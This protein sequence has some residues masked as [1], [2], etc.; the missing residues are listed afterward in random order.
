MVC[1]QCHTIQLQ[2]I[3]LHRQKSSAR[4]GSENKAAHTT[5]TVLT[6]TAY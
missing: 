2:S 5:T 1:S 4:F 6:V 3:N